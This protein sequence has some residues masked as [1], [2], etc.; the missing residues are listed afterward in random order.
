VVT[1]LILSSKRI[2]IWIIR[3]LYC[4]AFE[5]AD[6]EKIAQ[7]I[8]KRHPQLSEEEIRENL[9]TKVLIASWNLKHCSDPKLIKK[10]KHIKKKDIINSKKKVG[11]VANPFIG[12]H[13]SDEK[14]PV[15][16]FVEFL[17][18]F[19]DYFLLHGDSF[20]EKLSEYTILAKS[21]S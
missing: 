11:G 4:K 1:F 19:H 15:L 20:F 7:N 21:F 9:V 14:I 8:L 6:S 3:N 12:T 13:D 10:L 2:F 18:D 17:S 5:C 16:D